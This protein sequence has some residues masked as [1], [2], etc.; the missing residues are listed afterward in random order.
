MNDGFMRPAYPQQLIFSYYQASLVG[1]LIER[2]F[3][4]RAIVDMLNAY[5]T[6]ATTDA[7]VSA[8]AEDEPRAFDAKFDGYLKE[9][10]GK[11][12]AVIEPKDVRER[13]SAAGTGG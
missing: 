13:R 2:D 8:R 7:G 3:G 10:F 9:R 4:Q 6:G 1:E 11:L 12:M 5:K